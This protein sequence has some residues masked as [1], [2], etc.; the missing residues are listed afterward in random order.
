MSNTVYIGRKGQV[1][2]VFYR[3]EDAGQSQI[4]AV[5]DDEVD[6]HA[7]VA[8]FNYHDKGDGVAYICMPVL[9]NPDLPPDAQ[10]AISDPIS[11]YLY[12]DPG[13]IPERHEAAES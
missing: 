10:E 9:L 12:L 3:T 5:F 13:L 2:P 4:L 11:S 1:Y 8:W 6:A 7:Y